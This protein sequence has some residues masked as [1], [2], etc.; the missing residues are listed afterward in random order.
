[1]ISSRLFRIRNVGLLVLLLLLT[2]V[3]YGFAAETTFPDGG[4][5]AG[6]GVAEI[7]GNEVTNIKYTMSTGPGGGGTITEV[8]FDVSEYVSNVEIRL[9]TNDDLGNW[10]ACASGNGFSWTCDVSAGGGYDS[11]SRTRLHVAAWE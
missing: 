1:M 2:S 8:A 5:I 6:I 10:H 9:T 4:G 11:K 7:S 3:V